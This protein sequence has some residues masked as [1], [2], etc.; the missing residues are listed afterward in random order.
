[1][2]GRG[3]EDD[4]G[5]KERDFGKR[6]SKFKHN[7][8]FPAVRLALRE[9]PTVKGAAE[10]IQRLSPSCQAKEL[11]PLGVLETRSTPSAMDQLTDDLILLIFA[12]LAPINTLFDHVLSWQNYGSCYAFPM[13]ELS[14]HADERSLWPGLSKARLSTLR[15]LSYVCKRF[16]ELTEPLRWAHVTL[17]GSITSSSERAFAYPQLRRRHT[18]RLTIRMTPFEPWQNGGPFPFVSLMPTFHNIEVVTIIFMDHRGVL[19]SNPSS[20]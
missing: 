13:V 14:R 1:M 3:R 2:G 9:Q 15:T 17:H 18:R 12:I 6:D 19:N 5:R 8:N 20:V 11:A 10:R 4:D 7:E 16:R